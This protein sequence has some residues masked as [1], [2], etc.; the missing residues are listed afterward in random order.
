MILQGH[1]QW[2]KIQDKSFTL[3]FGQDHKQTQSVGMQNHGFAL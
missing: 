1:L 2:P 3:A